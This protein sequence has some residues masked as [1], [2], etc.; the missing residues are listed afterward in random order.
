[1]RL[2]STQSD[3]CYRCGY[4]L[5][6]IAN[7]QPCPECGLLAQRSRRVTDELHNTRPR[8][9]R[10]I[11]LGVWLTLLALFV[12]TAWQLLLTGFDRWI[13]ER[14]NWRSGLAYTMPWWGLD[15]G[16]L[17]LPVGMFLLTAAERYPPADQVDHRRRLLIRMLS[18][19]PLVAVLVQHAME[20]WARHGWRTLGWTTEPMMFRVCE[21]LL[22]F[23]LTLT[24]APL[25][26]LFFVQLGSLAKRV[27]SA[28][29]AE[30]CVIVGIGM[31]LSLIYGAV[32]PFIPDFGPEWN[33]GTPWTRYVSVELVL[34]LV[35]GVAIGLFMLWSLYLLLRFAIAF[36]RASRQLRRS[37]NR[38]DRA[39]TT[40]PA[41]H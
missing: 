10:R 40:D 27:R 9:L 18:F 5:R 26:L 37:W 11:S 4:D 1:M 41:L 38:D 36:H 8:W 29:L 31:S 24:M 15:F 28:H 39:R 17:L 30:H 32:K 12:T 14:W 2:E 19:V 34:D 21:T 13:D 20:A 7:D 6:G 25:P 3:E 35:A 16:A 23:V 22:P 33:L